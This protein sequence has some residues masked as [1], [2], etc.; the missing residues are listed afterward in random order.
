MKYSSIL[1]FFSVSQRPV[2]SLQTFNGMNIVLHFLIVH[3]SIW[4]LINIAECVL[5]NSVFNS[6]FCNDFGN[7]SGQAI[8]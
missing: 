1:E 2:L 5:K 6:I 3:S 4:D 8:E 7:K